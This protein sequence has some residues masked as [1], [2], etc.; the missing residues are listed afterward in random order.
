MSKHAS[1]NR[2]RI[3]R[4][5]RLVYTAAAGAAIVV[6]AGWAYASHDGARPQLSAQLGTDANKGAAVHGGPSGRTDRGA[7]RPQAL[8]DVSD[9]TRAAVPADSRQVVLVTGESAHS[10]HATVT[11]YTRAEGSQDWEPGP[12][13]PARNGAK[14][15]SEARDYGGLQSP[16]GVFSLTDAGGLL[17]EPPGTRLPY[18]RSDAFT[19]T[20]R[21]V[22]GESLAGSFDYV[23]AIN[24]NRATGA[25]PLDPTKPEGEAKGGNIWLH[26]DH[27]GPSQG[28][29]GIPAAGMKTLLQTLDPS[30]HPVIVMGPAGH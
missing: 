26:V 5:G 21:G 22:E 2:T 16:V 13:W 19:A 27:D 7:H 15:W 17:P 4:R 14:G 6:A 18:D 10:S 11:L 3:T 9:A 8:P 25:S 23:V 1:R 28:C 29:V 20:G 30:Q 12:S 24:F